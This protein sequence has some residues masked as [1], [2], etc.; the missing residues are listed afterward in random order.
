MCVFG[1]RGNPAGIKKAIKMNQPIYLDNAAT[2]SLDPKVASVM[3]KFNQTSWGNP[4]SQHNFGQRTLERLDQARE[5]I[6]DFL[7]AKFTE[8]IFTSGATEANNLGISGFIGASKI[9]KPHV[10]T[11]AIEHQSVLAVCRDLREEGKIELTEIKP[12][13]NGKHEARQFT[14]AVKPNTVLI[15]LMLVN[16]EL[17]TISPVRVLGKR[18]Q[19]INENRKIKIIFHSDVAQAIQYLNCRADYLKADLLTLSA[20]KIY[21]PVGIGVLYV[22]SKTNLRPIL[23]GGSQEFGLRPGT[24]NVA[25]AIGLAQAIRGLSKNHSKRIIELRE[26]FEGELKKALPTVEIIGENDSRTGIS[27]VFFPGLD[28][29]TLMIALDR[30]GVA[31]SVG[32]ACEAGA[33]T[34][35][36]VITA[37]RSY[38]GRG[39]N[40]RFS[41]GKFNTSLVIK[42]AIKIIAQT[43]Q[44]LAK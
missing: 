2:T 42:T 15:S 32:A 9:P 3:M 38:G 33:A 37:L 20:H 28:S 43:V 40:L 39:A 29:Q 34:K 1:A 10:I 7:G 16:N 6:A 5:L 8:I 24:V 17:G 22:R 26:E 31:A 35:S 19:K 36:H 30:A 44:R 23:T 41:F 14:K 18:I 21:G 25:G 27:N 13:R 4:A 11:S 12:D